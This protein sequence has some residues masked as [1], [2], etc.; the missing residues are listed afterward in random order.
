MCPTDCTLAVVSLTYAAAA[1]NGRGRA[2][3]LTDAFLIQCDGESISSCHIN[4]A[5]LSQDKPLC[6]AWLSGQ[7]LVVGTAGGV[8]LSVTRKAELR[9]N[10]MSAAVSTLSGSSG[11]RKLRQPAVARVLSLHESAAPICGAAVLGQSGALDHENARR[12]VL[13]VT[14]SALF[15]FPGV[16]DLHQVLEPFDSATAISIGLAIELDK[17]APSVHAI[18]QACARTCLQPLP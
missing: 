2:P 9:K 5:A 18:A 14:P 12:C 3:A 16:G 6:A 4:S 15:C 1:A 17:G 13:L 11:Q 10:G 7:Q 8:A